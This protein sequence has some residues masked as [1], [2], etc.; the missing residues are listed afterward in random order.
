MTSQLP[1]TG[2]YDFLLLRLSNR[3]K[4]SWTFL[5]V[6]ER[7]NR[8]WIVW[9]VT[10]RVSNI[11]VFYFTVLLCVFAFKWLLWMNVIVG[12][13]CR[14]LVRVGL[15]LQNLWHPANRMSSSLSLARNRARQY[16]MSKRRQRESV[17]INEEWYC[18]LFW[19]AYTDRP[20]LIISVSMLL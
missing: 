6:N 4:E 13:T 14:R 17:L 19:P 9:R 10:L 11:N 15:G 20:L 1:R 12:E 2:I 18:V 8:H 16:Q 3:G 7:T 5:A